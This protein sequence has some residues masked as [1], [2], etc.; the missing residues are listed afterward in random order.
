MK[1]LLFSLSFCV[2]VILLISLIYTSRH[3]LII[4]DITPINSCTHLIQK[5]DILFVIPA[6]KNY[7]L[8][9]YPHWC[10]EIKKLNKTIGLHGITHEYHEFNKNITH[11]QLEEAISLFANCVGYKPLIFRPPYNKIS[12]ENKLLIESYNMTI[13]KDNYLIRPYCHCEPKLWMKP[14]N[15]VIGC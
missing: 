13:Y 4:D 3:P 14:L 5:A 11:V 6:Y 9:L 2:L 7:S 8:T 15:W 1:K 12:T 10:Q